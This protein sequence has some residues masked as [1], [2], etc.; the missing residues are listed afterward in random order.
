V[1]GI[2]IIRQDRHR[3]DVEHAW[4]MIGVQ[5]VSPEAFEAVL[6][7]GS[8]GGWESLE[9]KK[10]KSSLKRSAPI[11]T[12]EDGNRVDGEAGEP[13][14]EAGTSRETSDGGDQRDRSEKAKKRVRISLLER[15]VQE[16]AVADSLLR[17]D[18]PKGALA[19]LAVMWFSNSQRSLAC[20]DMVD[21]PDT[22]RSASKQ[23][24]LPQEVAGAHWNACT[25]LSQILLQKLLQTRAVSLQ[26]YRKLHN[27]GTPVV[28]RRKRIDGDRSARPAHALC[29]NI[30]THSMYSYALA[31]IPAV[32][33]PLLVVYSCTQALIIMLHLA[34]WL[35]PLQ[36]RRVLDLRV[37]KL[38]DD[39]GGYPKMMIVIN[40]WYMSSR[41]K[42]CGHIE[43]PSK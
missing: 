37:S 38:F 26:L 11:D 14:S 18:K 25:H 15:E 42:G 21:G 34:K 32:I 29:F 36:T 24:I 3:R 23:R 6:L 22:E 10:T 33:S 30:W 12:E 41:I 43:Q 7:L 19:F 9:P 35:A 27:D 28:A 31:P 40:P 16:D 2:P 17:E 1:S 5:P 4:S 8:K 13:K 20:A 39:F